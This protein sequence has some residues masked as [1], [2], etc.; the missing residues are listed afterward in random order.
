MIH[1]L[2]TNSTNNLLT[3]CCQDLYSA[4]S[5]SLAMKTD[6]NF[7]GATISGTDDQIRLEDPKISAMIT[8]FTDNS[9]GSRSDAILCIIPGLRKRIK[10]R[11]S[12]SLQSSLTR[13]LGDGDGENGNAEVLLNWIHLHS[14][15]SEREGSSITNQQV[16]AS[17]LI[18][19]CEFYGMMFAGNQPMEAR[20]SRY[21]KLQRM[22]KKYRPEADQGGGEVGKIL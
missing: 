3:E 19:V 6:C 7:D 14:K 17:N 13:V 9:L 5:V 1:V 21:R 18:T 20:H 10:L 2:Y 12:D 16:F 8:A 22:M 15:E 11:N 4:L